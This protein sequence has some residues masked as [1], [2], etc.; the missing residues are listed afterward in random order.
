M[1]KKTQIDTLMIFFN[2][3]KKF[4]TDG[5]YRIRTINEDTVELA[6]LVAGSCGETL[7]HPQITVSLTE[8][9][10]ALGIKLIDMYTTP[11]LFLH[12]NNH[13][14][15]E[16]DKALDHLIEKFSSKIKNTKTN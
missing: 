15:H 4:M 7:V 14:A 11:P 9:K 1:K 13:T 5:Y 12:R 16:I 3:E 6:F 2:D 10:Q 8:S